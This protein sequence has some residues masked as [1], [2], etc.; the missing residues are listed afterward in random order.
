MYRLAFPHAIVFAPFLSG[1]T[2]HS[3]HASAT[4]G[5]ASGS[6]VASAYDSGA[7]ALFMTQRVNRFPNVRELTRKD[8]CVFWPCCSCLNFFLFHLLSLIAFSC[9]HECRAPLPAGAHPPL[10]PLSP[11]CTDCVATWPPCKVEGVSSST[12]STLFPKRLCCRGSTL[13]F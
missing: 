13:R 10:S 1:G 6:S 12:H 4:S 8:G 11:L 2:P 5:S 9:R 3:S 7:A